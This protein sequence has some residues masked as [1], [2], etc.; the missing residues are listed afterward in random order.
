MDFEKQHTLPYTL[1]GRGNDRNTRA[2]RLICEPTEDQHMESF[3]IDSP[4]HSF[5][6][7]LEYSFKK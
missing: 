3:V 6:I 5:I 7:Q 2:T 4:I 1:Q